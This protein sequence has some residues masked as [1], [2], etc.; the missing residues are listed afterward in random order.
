MTEETLADVMTNEEWLTLSV[1]ANA[2]KLELDHDNIFLKDYDAWIYIKE[3]VSRIDTIQICRRYAT[4]TYPSS[5]RFLLNF[6]NIQYVGRYIPRL[7]DT[8]QPSNT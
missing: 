2:Q 7:L 6:Y 1:I 5:I 3:G 4:D 8:A